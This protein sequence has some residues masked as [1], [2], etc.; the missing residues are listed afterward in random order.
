MRWTLPG[1]PNNAVQHE[2]WN[3]DEGQ[4]ALFQNLSDYFTNNGQNTVLANWFSKMF[5]DALNRYHAAGITFQAP[6]IPGSGTDPQPGLQVGSGTD[7]KSGQSKAASGGLTFD[8]WLLD[9]QDSFMN[10]F[11]MQ[12]PTLRGSNPGLFRTTRQLW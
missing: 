8:R 4:R 12:A 1:D 11:N 2:Y 5:P 10:S 6:D 7:E 9:N 3:T